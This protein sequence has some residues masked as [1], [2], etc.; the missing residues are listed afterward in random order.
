MKAIERDK[1]HQDIYAEVCSL[2]RGLYGEDG[3]EGDIPEIK[4]IL[5]S[6]NTK[7]QSHDKDITKFKTGIKIA[8][9]SLG[10]G[11]CIGGGMAGIL[12]ALGVY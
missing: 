3:F 11:G 10:S 7:L 4:K 2:K 9:W 1:L 12:K 6:Q 8:V 5:N